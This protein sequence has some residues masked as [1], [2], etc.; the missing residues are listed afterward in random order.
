VT[1]P[2]RLAAVDR[3]ATEAA[4]E[5]DSERLPRIARHRHD[6]RPGVGADAERRRPATTADGVRIKIDANIEFP[7]DLVAARYAGAEGV[8]LYRSEFLLAGGGPELTD[9]TDEGQQYEVYRSMLEGM[10]PGTVTVRT[11]DVDEDQLALRWSEPPL[12]AG[13]APEEPRAS[14][15]GL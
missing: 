2:C 4:V 1:Q 10:A 3:G 9:I 11:F 7:D 14:R 8:G 5:P 15:L 13:W 6:D 12:A